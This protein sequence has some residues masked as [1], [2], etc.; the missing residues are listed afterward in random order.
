MLVKLKNQ[1]VIIVLESGRETVRNLEESVLGRSF[2]GTVRPLSLLF[3]IEE[4][5]KREKVGRR[6]SFVSCRR[7]GGTIVYKALSKS[8]IISEL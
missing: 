7:N 1:E 4:P 8:N 6:A 2:C 5:K 3:M